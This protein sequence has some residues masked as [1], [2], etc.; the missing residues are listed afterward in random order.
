V[1]GSKVRVRQAFKDVQNVPRRS[2]AIARRNQ[3]NTRGDFEN[4]RASAQRAARVRSPCM[5]E[6]IGPVAGPLQAGSDTL[7]A[8]TKPVTLRCY[9]L[10]LISL[11]M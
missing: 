1:H 9:R 8:A 6:Q 2:S 10:D 7:Q 5:K 11:G 3:R 4:E